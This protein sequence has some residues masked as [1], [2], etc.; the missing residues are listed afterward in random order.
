MRIK[1]NNVNDA[2]WKELI[3][4]SN[5]PEKLSKLQEIAGNLWW[6]WNS[7]AKNM[8]RNICKESWIEAQSNPVRLLNIL[9]YE[10]LQALAEDAKFTAEL[11][12]IYEKYKNIISE[13]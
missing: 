13:I 7:D 5:L 8:F 4:K 12:A 3:V 11:D 10:K 2:N 9:S 6:V 1:V